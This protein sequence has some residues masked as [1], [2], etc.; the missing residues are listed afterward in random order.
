MIEAFCE[1][2]IDQISRDPKQARRLFDQDELSGLAASI[3][4]CGVIEPLVVREGLLPGSFVLVAGERRWRAAGMARL[5]TVPCVIRGQ[6]GANPA[7]VA[8][9]E[10]VQRAPLTPIEEALAYRRLVVGEGRTQ[11][12]LANAIGKSQSEI[13]H[14]IRLLSLPEPVQELIDQRQLGAGHGKVLLS[15]PESTRLGLGR[16]AAAKKWSVRRLEQEVRKIRTAAGQGSGAALREAEASGRQP[17]VST[18][19]RSLERQVGEAVGLPVTIRFGA[20]GSGEVG[21]QCSSLD[22]LDGLLARLGVKPGC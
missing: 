2:G 18:E 15:A 5:E 21:F 10:N 9:A 4:Y 12:D 20:S 6:G 16:S 13:A 17:A 19:I 7:E 1:I 3:A 22:E 11:G 14:R 8:L